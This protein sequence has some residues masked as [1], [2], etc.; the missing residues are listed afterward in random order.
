MRGLFVIRWFGIILASSITL[1]AQ[2]SSDNG[3]FTARSGPFMSIGGGAVYFNDANRYDAFEKHLKYGANIGTGAYINPY[4]SVEV[5]FQFM[6][7]FQA[8]LEGDVKEV[9][10]FHWNIATIAHYPLFHA[11]IDPFV[12]FGAGEV[13]WDEGAKEIES[14][15][16]SAV[17][18]G[19]GVGYRITPT[20]EIRLGV[21]YI[22]FDLFSQSKNII[23]EQSHLISSLSLEVMF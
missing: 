12:K 6:Q 16:A 10:F 5:L 17:L 1:F 4:L 19:T 20:Y 11:R 3:S 18:I 7:P 14:D 8:T 21:D 13:F 9:S 23:Y 15:S 2:V 22:R